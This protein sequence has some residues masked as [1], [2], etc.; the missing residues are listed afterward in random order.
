[1]LWAGLV[2]WLHLLAAIFWVGGQLFLV[3]V[4]LPVLRQS[5]PARS[6]VALRCPRPLRWASSW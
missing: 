3:A 6:V 1:M 5:L 4:V 2:L